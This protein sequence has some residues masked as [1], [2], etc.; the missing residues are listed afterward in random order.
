MRA[1]DVE[2]QVGV[3]DDRLGR[4]RDDAHRTARRDVVAVEG[5]VEVARRVLAAAELAEQLV[6]AGPEVGAAGV[7]A[8]DGELRRAG[9]LLEDLVGDA[10]HRAPHL[11]GRQDDCLTCVSAFRHRKNATGTGS[12]YGS[13]IHPLSVSQDTVKGRERL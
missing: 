3:L 8:D 4:A 10:H 2:R 13:V 6:D 11:V 9:V 7:D 12:R 5:D 1:L